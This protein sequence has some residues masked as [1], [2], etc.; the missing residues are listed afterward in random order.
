MCGIIGF[1]D[2]Q[3][4]LGKIV[5]GLERLEYRGYDSSGLA[6]LDKNQQS[7][8]T[9]V[10]AAGKLAALKG[11]LAETPNLAGNIGVGHT[12]WA[13]HGTPSEKNAHP[14][15]A[16]KV[17]VVHNG[18]I[19]NFH[20]LQHELKLQG[21]T[22]VTDTDTEVAAQLI[23]QHLLQGLSA[24]EAF[25][26]CIKSLHGTYALAAIITG[27]ERIF[28]AKNGSPLALAH[29]QQGVALGSDAYAL[30]PFSQQVIYLED[31]D[32][33]ILSHQGIKIFDGT[34]NTVIRQAKPIKMQDVQEGKGDYDHYMLKEIF[35]QPYAVGNTL[36]AFIDASK[37]ELQLPLSNKQ[38]AKFTKVN[39]IACGTSYY[40]GL[41]AKYWLQHLAGIPVE[42]LVGSE[43]K[44][45]SPV[46]GNN[47]LFVLISQSGE[48]A[49]TITC[50]KMIKQQGHYIIG[51]INAR[52]TS[53]ERLCD[54]VLHTAAGPEISVA[55]TKA[56]T[57]QLMILAIL[58]L[59]LGEVRGKLSALKISELLGQLKEIPSKLQQALEIA[60]TIPPLAE[61]LA[62]FNNMLYLARGVLSPLAFE[63]A[64]KLKEVSYI[65]VEAAAAGE[66][67][68]GVIAL[69]DESFPV[70]FFAAKCDPLFDKLLGNIQ[71]VLAR[72]APVVAI[73]DEEGAKVLVKYGVKVIIIPEGKFLELP[74]ISVIPAQLLA[75]FVAVSRGADVDQPR[76]LAKSV[77]V[78]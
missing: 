8:P 46:T 6:L 3:N 18:I 26:A 45:S 62:G 33:A 74:F 40:A 16:G 32:Y 73:T 7:P 14:I 48:T 52:E 69:I 53:M 15:T 11:K 57:A 37:H 55:S 50:A 24:E 30:M 2:L 43:Y 13:T 71:E 38:L 22:F 63:A 64:L 72:K 29:T 58:A 27:E 75:Y 34:G 60:D 23:N 56:F 19:E 47:E 65:H 39:I 78:E 76:N 68:H 59:K 12:R 9:V 35:E 4:A 67:K 66:M 42:V 77:T 36:S 1:V 41:I 51:I 28:V 49:D 10:K 31:G 44:Y 61:Y 20:L 70:V 17:A 54:Q 21:A 5:T 25:T